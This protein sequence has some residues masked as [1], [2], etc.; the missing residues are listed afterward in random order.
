M[1]N[2]NHIKLAERYL[3]LISNLAR[4]NKLDQAAKESL[5]LAEIFRLWADEDFRDR[6][7]AVRGLNNKK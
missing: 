5:R 2:K 1:T 7:A 3:R 4:Q 6:V